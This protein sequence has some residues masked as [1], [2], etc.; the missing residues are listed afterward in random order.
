MLLLKFDIC[1]PTIELAGSVT[2]YFDCNGVLVEEKFKS[3]LATKLASFIEQHKKV[4]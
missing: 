1:S 4:K 3:A 2:E